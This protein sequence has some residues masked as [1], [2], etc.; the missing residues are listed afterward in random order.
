MVNVKIV[1]ALPFLLLR[2]K[3]LKGKVLATSTFHKDF[4]GRITLLCGIAL[5]LHFILLQFP[6]HYYGVKHAE[7]F[8]QFNIFK[9]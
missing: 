9:V 7:H 6:L 1:K 3:A 4:K 8:K 5:L 2:R